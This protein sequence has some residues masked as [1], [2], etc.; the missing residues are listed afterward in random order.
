MHV[1]Q[2]FRDQVLIDLFHSEHRIDVGIGFIGE[3]VDFEIF[4][5]SDTGHELDPKEVGQPEDREA[6]GMRIPITVWGLISDLLGKK[7]SKMNDAS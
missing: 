2:V 3:L 6:L 4:P 1:H 7:G 5:P